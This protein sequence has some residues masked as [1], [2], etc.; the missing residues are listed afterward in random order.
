MKKRIFSFFAVVALAFSAM[1]QP[2]MP[3]FS[4]GGAGKGFDYL[5]AHNSHIVANLGDELLIATWETWGFLGTLA[6]KGLQVVAVDKN[7]KEL[8]QVSLPDTRMHELVFANY[9]DGRV[10][11][12]YR[13]EFLPRYYR[14]VVEPRS[15]TLESC[16]QVFDKEV[17]KN[18]VYYHWHAQSDNKLFFA[19]AEVVVSDVSKEMR[20]R[21][22]LLDEKMEVLWEKHFETNVLSELRVSD[23]GE[24]YLFGSRYDS[25]SRETVVSL[26]VLDVDDER[27]VNGRVRIGE[28]YG[29]ELVNIVGGGESSSPLYA[30]AAGY[31]RSSESP[32]KK[33]W[34]D[35]MVGMSLNIR[36]GELKAKAVRFTSDELN[37]FGNKGTKK[38]N[39]V[40]MTDALVM[41]NSVGTNYGGVMLLQRI[42]KVTTRSTKAPDVHDYYTMGSLAFG[43]DTT[44]AIL[45]HMPFRTVT[46]ERT[47]SAFDV[48]CY[49]DAP[50]LAEGD[51]VYVMLPESSKTTE[52]YDITSSVSKIKLGNRTHAS[53][54]YGIDRLGQVAKQIPIPKDKASLMDNMV[55]LEEGKYMGVCSFYKKSALVYVDFLK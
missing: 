39:K 27:S 50:M 38:E 55:R 15:M 11:L 13:D 32:K 54:V 2:Q 44:A 1:A 47:G 8:R 29:L 35:Q 21:Q 31:I 18:T 42:W 52:T 34:F 10:Y 22:I 26:H 30:V 45:W 17:G 3:A 40:G 51:N 14:A 46:G 37:V 41:A 19:M 53:V 33:D 7:L 4:F 12:L 16:E 49:G 48:P 20:H 25:E 23:D 36:T 43:V 28:V 6:P 5:M 24:V 9:V